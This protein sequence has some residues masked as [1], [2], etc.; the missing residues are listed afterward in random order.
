M[1]GSL[2]TDYY[3]WIML[4][5]SSIGWS[6]MLLC[7][8]AMFIEVNMT[9]VLERKYRHPLIVVWLCAIFED[10]GK[11]KTRDELDGGDVACVVILFFGLMWTGMSVA[12]PISITAL[13]YYIGLRILR[14]MVRIKKA[15]VKLLT[16][17]KCLKEYTE[18]DSPKMEF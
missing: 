13:S 10:K 2:F 18:K 17:K 3:W 15:V 16:N 6:I 4:G 8:L 7:I 14:F 5:F 9:Y 12:W 11:E 1:I